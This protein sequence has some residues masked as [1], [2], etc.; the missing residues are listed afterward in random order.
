MTTGV[1][2]GPDNHEA[3][4]ND[5]GFPL[6]FFSIRTTLQ[7]LL[8]KY[9]AEDIPIMPPPTITIFFFYKTIKLSTH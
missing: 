2:D 1:I 4:P 5:A 6:K 9:R 7:P 3:L 8:I